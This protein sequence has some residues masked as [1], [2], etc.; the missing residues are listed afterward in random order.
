MFNDFMTAD[1]LT[2]FA[3]ITGATMLIVQFTKSLIKNKLGDSFV[4]IYSFIISLILTFFF[5]NTGKEAQDIIMMI[6]N[7]ILITITS[8]GGYEMIT[9][10]MAKKNK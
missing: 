4:R 1:V 7:A 5:A 3:G 8:M 6:L 9:D 2:T 10:P